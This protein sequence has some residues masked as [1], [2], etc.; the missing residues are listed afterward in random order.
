M[1]IRELL[2]GKKKKEPSFILPQRAYT[3]YLISGRKFVMDDVQYD[4]IR[5]IIEGEGYEL[6]Y[7]PGIL[8]SLSKAVMKYNFP[9]VKID[10]TQKDF[11][12]SV[13]H[14]L[15]INLGDDHACLVWYNDDLEIFEHTE[16]QDS[17]EAL[18]EQVYIKFNAVLESIDSDYSFSVGSADTAEEICDYCQHLPME[19]I[20]PSSC[21]RQSRENKSFWRSRIPVERN[22]YELCDD[23]DDEVESAPIFSPEL[24]LLAQEAKD[25]ID[26]LLLSGFSAE[27]IKGWLDQKV[28][29]SRIR[30]TKRNKI[31][32]E[33]YDIEVKM[34]P[35]PKTVFLFFLRHP[36]GMRF[37]DLQ[38]YKQE[39]YDIYSRLAVSDDLDKIKRS[40]DLLT[41]PFDNSINEKCTMIKYAFQK[42]VKDD[43][44]SNYYVSGKQGHTMKIPLDRTLV[45]WE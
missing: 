21:Q 6:F 5:D 2:F 26:K 43:I 31:L 20:E 45:E 40:V 14:Q 7:M 27:V 32:L 37:V 39:I 8:P 3:Y 38:D 25:A 24:D 12:M 44:A 4:N 41:N 10:F 16:P 1:S 36:E 29:L 42:V 35:L 30:I 9:G 11:S 13:A 22:L 34:G 18:H 28:K 19:E 15:N 17:F 33:D 23:I